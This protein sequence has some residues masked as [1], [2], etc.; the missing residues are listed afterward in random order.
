MYFYFLLSFTGTDQ[1]KAVEMGILT[2]QAD[3]NRV[4]RAVAWLI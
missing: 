3:F 1:S 4:V 2:S